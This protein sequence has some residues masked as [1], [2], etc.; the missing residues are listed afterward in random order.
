V[1]WRQCVTASASENAAYKII[2]FVSWLSVVLVASVVGSTSALNTCPSR[3]SGACRPRN[4]AVLS[5]RH[6][7]LFDAASENKT[8]SAP[9]QWRFSSLVWPDGRADR[10]ALSRVNVIVELNCRGRE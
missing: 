6:D 10:Q 7:G 9:L 8:S 2:K 4:A 3:S 1:T 5:E